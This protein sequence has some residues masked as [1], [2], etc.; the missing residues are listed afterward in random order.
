MALQGG[1]Q[2]GDHRTAAGRRRFHRADA[3]HRRAGRLG[4]R[5]RA[6]GGGSAGAGRNEVTALPTTLVDAPWLTHGVLPRLLAALNRDGEEARVI[7]GAVRN[8]LIGETPS[9]IDIAT[10]ATPDEVTRRAEAAGFKAV[11]TGIEHG[12]VTI[13]IDGRPF[14]VTTLR[15]D[16][17]T[18][19]R[20]AKVAFGRDWKADAERRDFTMNALSV[21]M[22]GEVH[23]YVNGLADL[24]E[25]RVVFIGDPEKRIAED[26]LRILRFFRFHAAYGHGAPDPA[27][28]HACIVARA[29]LDQ[30][31]R[32]RVRME[33]IK[34]LTAARAA[35]TLTVMAEAGLLGRVLGGVPLVPSFADMVAAEA[36]VGAAPDPVRR[37]AALA[38]TVVEDAERLWQRLRLSNTEHDRLA[39]MADQWRSIMPANG[40]QAAR[41]LLY[42]LG[43]HRFRDRVLLAWARSPAQAGDPAWQGLASLPDRWMAPVFPLKAADF[44]AHGVAKGPALGEALRSAE[45]EWVAA[46]FPVDAAALQRIIAAALESVAGND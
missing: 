8:A 41:A 36:V 32:E 23:D 10:T 16:V 35:A 15:Q 13:V 43:P 12:T 33:L 14:E 42:R 40:D 44:M 21:G 18:Y 30:L 27:G 37:L 5:A 3:F 39:S 45:E 25:R 34:L 38:V 17:E 46:D 22:D 1:R 31:S 29:G 28:L 9:E 11:P 20:K 24:G 4:L 7:G 2:P 26:Y 6:C 19:G